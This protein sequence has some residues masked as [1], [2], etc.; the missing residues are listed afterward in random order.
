MSTLAERSLKDKDPVVESKPNV[1]AKAIK[2]VVE[3]RMQK[4]SPVTRLGAMKT[5]LPIS[6]YI[7]FVYVDCASW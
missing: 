7:F 5:S 2:P 4:S 1:G 6:L 3:A